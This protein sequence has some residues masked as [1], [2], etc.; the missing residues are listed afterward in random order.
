MTFRSL[1]LGWAVACAGFA[2]LAAPAPQPPNILLIFTDDQGV[3]DVGS[4]GSEI[5]T[6]HI[7]SIARD[8]IK[9]NGF[10][11]ASAVCTPARF[12]LLTGRNPSRSRDQLIAPLMFL[13]DADRHRGLRP[14][15]TTLAAVLKQ[16]G[17]ATA[18]I[19]KWHLGHGESEFFPEHHGFQ[20]SYGHT[21]GCVDYFT[22][23]YGNVPDWYR[24][25]RP[26]EESGYATDLITDEAVRYLK[27]RRSSQPFFLYLAYNAPHFGKGWDDEANAP[28]NILQ[29]HPRDLERARFIEDPK[30]RDFAAMTMALDDGIGRVLRSVDEMGLRES[31]IVIFL[32]DNGGEPVA[33]GSNLPLRGNKGSLF[34]GGIKVPGLVRWPGKI[35][36]GS[37]TDAV[38]WGLDWFPTLARIAGA[39]TEGLLLD[40]QDI[41]TVLEGKEL[42][43]ERELFWEMAQPDRSTA[44][45]RQGNWKFVRTLEGEELLFDLAV[46]PLEQKNL[47]PEKPEVLAGL[48]ARSDQ[49]HRHLRTER[50]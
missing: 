7:D 43:G 29:P 33:G 40:G 1:L 19:G 32:T 34:E 49:L 45:L 24:N 21:G 42:T 31:T 26:I 30:R 27:E 13:S 3:H 20:H 8:G 5:P 11:S 28:V 37:Q 9:L 25:G 14:G 17:Y 16:A 35:R 50:P 39:S 4:Y 22:L 15:E 41:G 18:V 38:V 47:A 2:A 6:P 36:A 10:Y 44:A 23:A 46:D 48:R 12:G